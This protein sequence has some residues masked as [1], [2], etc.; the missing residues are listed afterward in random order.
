MRKMKHKKKEAELLSDIPYQHILIA[1]ATGSI[2]TS[3]SEALARGGKSLYFLV[4]NLEAGASLAEKC[5][6]LGAKETHV[7]SFD[8][9]DP[10]T[11]AAFLKTAKE[12]NLPLE[13]FLNISG[14]YHQKEDFS[15]LLEKTYMIN[16]VR[17]FHFIERLWQQYPSLTVLTVSSLTAARYSLKGIEMNKEEEYLTYFNGVKNK[18]KRYAFSKALL[19]Y[20]LMKKKREGKRVIFVHPGVTCSNLFH[21]KNNAYSKAF[22]LIAPPLMRLIFMSPNRACLSLLVGLNPSYVEEKDCFWIAPRGLLEAWGY[23]K[24]HPLKKVFQ[25]EATQKK[26]SSFLES[27]H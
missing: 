18:T 15:S 21:P 7:F 2:G 19:L 14:I 6:A 9:S 8:Y 13:V 1:G 4:R 20:A 26:V 23:P 5:L 11:M 27:I 25:K 16:A 17:P 10:S 24:K 3:T 12:R 22:Y